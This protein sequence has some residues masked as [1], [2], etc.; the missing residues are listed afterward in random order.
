MAEVNRAIARLKEGRARYR[1][2]LSR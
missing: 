2:V 1:I